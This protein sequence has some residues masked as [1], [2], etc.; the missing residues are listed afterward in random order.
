MKIHRI[1][2]TLKLILITK[3]H[4][5][6]SLLS[7]QSPSIPNKVFLQNILSEK[8]SVQGKTKKLKFKVFTKFSYFIQY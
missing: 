3:N 6:T 4:L 5:K 2:E 1:I 7:L 8:N